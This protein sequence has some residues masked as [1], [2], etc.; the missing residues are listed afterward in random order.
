[1]TVL[2]LV[3]HAVTEATGKRLTGSLPGVHLSKEGRRQASLLGDRLAN[4]PLAALYS[5]PLER[6]LETAEA[7]ASGRGV[8]IQ[9]LGDL[10]EIRFGR[11]TGRPLAQLAKTTLW[12]QVHQHPSSVRFPE[13]E[14]LAEAQHRS[15]SAV[16]GIAERHPRGTIAVVSHGDVIRLL[17]A[18]YTG[19]HIDLFQR[20]VVAP[21][22]VSAVRLA[23]GVPYVLRVNDTGSADDLLE[24][25]G[26]RRR[27]RGS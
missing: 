20:L 25:S 1:M 15:V 12:K 10:E 23:D 24:H 22:S 8:A 5:S 9:S 13:G 3:R 11:W 4:L 21:A 2:L 19:V 18:H 26:R 7:I 27:R 14:T 6:C 16:S 17:L